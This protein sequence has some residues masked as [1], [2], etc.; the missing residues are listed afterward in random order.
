MI[1]VYKAG[2][3]W[4]KE[5]GTEYTIK[6]ANLNEKAGLIKDGWVS[7]LDEVKAKPKAKAKKAIKDDNKE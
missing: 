6:S 1:H 3:D 2:G 5:D 4:K 7:S